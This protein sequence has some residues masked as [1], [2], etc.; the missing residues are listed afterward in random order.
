MVTV[1]AVHRHKQPEADSSVLS[2]THHVAVSLEDLE[3]LRRDKRLDIGHYFY[4]HL[5]H[6]YHRINSNEMKGKQFLI[7]HI[8]AE[9]GN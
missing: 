7:M 1:C 9:N 5:P 4:F 2:P 3:V 6:E 8:D